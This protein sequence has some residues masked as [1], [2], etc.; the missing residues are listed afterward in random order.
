MKNLTLGKRRRDGMH[1]V[2]LCA[3]GACEQPKRVLRYP[4]YFRD[5][6]R[7]SYERQ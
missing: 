7:K 2:M 3:F 4:W 1:L 5:P 6:E